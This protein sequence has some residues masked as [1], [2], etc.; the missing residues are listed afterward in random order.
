[1]S[2]D[3]QSGTPA[4]LPAVTIN[5][6]VLRA[7]VVAPVATA[8]EHLTTTQLQ[9]NTRRFNDQAYHCDFEQRSIGYSEADHRTDYFTADGSYFSLLMPDK[10]TPH[11]AALLV[12][13]TQG[14]AAGDLLMPIASETLNMTIHS[15]FSQ[16]TL[17]DKWGDGPVRCSIHAP[18]GFKMVFGANADQG[19]V[20]SLMQ[21]RR[22][23]ESGKASGGTQPALE[24][25]NKV[26]TAT[27]VFTD[28]S[29][30]M[31]NQI[32][33]TLCINNDASL[34]LAHTPQ[35]TNITILPGQDGLVDLSLSLT[36]SHAPPRARRVE[37][38]FRQ[39]FLTSVEQDAIAQQELL[40][41]SLLT[42]ETQDVHAF[43]AGSRA[44]G[45]RFL[46][47]FG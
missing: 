32:N 22:I 5:E 15:H 38:L 42:P 1:M 25:V 46:T 7:P 11:S 21:V 10:C 23:I 44:G 24:W 31:D 29:N 45:P 17:M 47:P 8:L 12:A 13:N 26:V 33:F 6:Q 37:S 20:G 4:K 14:F 3:W 27:T 35:N 36:L 2:V 34:D 28:T 18:E 19:V 41:F 40:S 39:D 43:M 9:A 16:T 30:R